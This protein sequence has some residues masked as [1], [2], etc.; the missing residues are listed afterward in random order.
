MGTD[1]PPVDPWINLAQLSHCLTEQFAQESTLL[2][3]AALVAR[4]VRA[5]ASRSPLGGCLLHDTA[6]DALYLL[7]EGGNPWTA[8]AAALAPL[9]GREGP[10]RA[11][12]PKAFHLTGHLL[13]IEPIVWQDA[14]LGAVALAVREDEPEAPVRAVLSVC[15]GMV[16][17]HFVAGDVPCAQERAVT[18]GLANLGELARP[19]THTFNNFL[20]GLV[21]KVAV[22]E[23][24]LPD[25][26]RPTL[27]QLRQQATEVAELIKRF[28]QYRQLVDPATARADVNRAVREAAVQAQRADAARNG[29]TIALELGNDLPAVVGTLAEWRRCMVFLL[30]NALRA[31]R[32]GRVLARTARV[33][34]QVQIQVEDEGPSLDAAQVGKLFE[35]GGVVRPGTQP[36]ELASCRSIVR[37]LGGKLRAETY[38]S[39]G[40]VVVIDLPTAPG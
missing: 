26:F 25:S 35:L 1:S 4:C 36:L 34:T 22:L 39:G 8:D 31:T 14:R 30:A 33:G 7:D 10:A 17:P 24:Q 28:Q 11:P 20:N 37:R 6:G 12:V 38:P 2:G 21:L 19:L 15:A 5:A 13:L 40:M 32:K 9:L 27:G 16:A 29:A 18:D 3:R 23:Q